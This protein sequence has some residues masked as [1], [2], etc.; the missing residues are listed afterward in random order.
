MTL[1][2]GIDSLKASISR[3]GGMA[4][5]NR[6]AIY[7]THPTKNQSL[8]NTDVASLAGNAARSVLA[9]GSP[10]LT[11]FIEDPRDIY[12]F[13]E[14]CNIPGR[15]VTTTEHF[16][17]MKAVKKPYGFLNED[18]NF[19]FNLTNDYYIWKY[20]TA[21]IDFII[22]REGNNG[23]YMNYLENFGQ[24][25]IIQQMGNTDFIP[26]YTVRLK[27]AYP[28]TLNSIELSN[29]N[30]NTIV[31]CTTTFTYQDWEEVSL[32]D[33]FR[34]LVQAGQSIITNSQSALTTLN[35]NIGKLF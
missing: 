32:V 35:R 27:K 16:T 11:S 30:E 25:V 19:A 1:P 22:L 24:D 31:Q 10:S 9:G 5:S 15:Q 23:Y 33:G 29:S 21:W 7:M 17:S 2:A 13:C 20:L 8:L 28:I 34:D 14:S 18:V 12:L 26:V 3:R 6:F 4:R